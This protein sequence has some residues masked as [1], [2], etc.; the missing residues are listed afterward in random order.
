M[1]KL[2][3]VCGPNG[4]GKTTICKEIVQRLDNSAY[5]DS[6]C[7]QVYQPICFRG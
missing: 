3:F 5:V 7:L 4:I 6:G 2:I 1:K